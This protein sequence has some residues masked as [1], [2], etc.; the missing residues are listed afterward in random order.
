MSASS[1]LALLALCVDEFAGG[2][3]CLGRP[4]RDSLLSWPEASLILFAAWNRL[5]SSFEEVFWKTALLCGCETVTLLCL[6][7]CLLR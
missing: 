2:E 5:S 4:S 6:G 7:I 1:M 3:S